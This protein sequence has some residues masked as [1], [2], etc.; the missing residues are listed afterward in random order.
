MGAMVLEG[1][2]GEHEWAV[3]RANRRCRAR[4]VRIFSR[5][6]HAPFGP[7]G[8]MSVCPTDTPNRVGGPVLVS[9]LCVV[10][11]ALPE[12]ENL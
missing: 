3:W 6:A 7:R 2:S 1:A 4:F 5:P 8:A 9:G 10:S 11:E 12:P